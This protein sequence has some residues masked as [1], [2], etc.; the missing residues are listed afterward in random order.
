MYGGGEEQMS[1]NDDTQSSPFEHHAGFDGTASQR[2]DDETPPP[3][4]YAYP[5]PNDSEA[6][7]APA[8]AAEPWSIPW[9]VA[10]TLVAASVIVVA[11]VAVIVV[12]VTNR[13]ASS[14][15]PAAAPTSPTQSSA[16]PSTVAAPPPVTV[17]SEETITDTVTAT[18]PVPT[19]PTS[20]YDP[21]SFGLQQ[22]QQIANNDQP[23]VLTGATSPDR[24][25]PQL[26]SKKFGIM[27]DGYS[28]DY[29]R[30]VQ[31]F[32]QLKRNYPSA[33]LLRSADW[34]TFGESDFWVTIAGI[35][36][37][38]AS[39][40]LSWCSRNGLDNNHCY[41]KLL[42]VTQGVEGSTAYQ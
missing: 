37:P 28:Y 9:P 35:A 20:S 13:G 26:G 38:T 12:I 7:L 1:D 11:L 22:L 19:A 6:K 42:S 31:D 5:Q 17:T 4:I 40:A 14:G 23:V 16:A 29:P 10:V 24:W 39:G 18:A 33:R 36:F 32:Y 2:D 34:S 3:V 25:V 41:A 27:V 21:E 8:K 30:I 15:P